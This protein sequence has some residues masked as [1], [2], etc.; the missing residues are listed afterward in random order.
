VD[1]H[2]DNEDK[3]TDIKTAIALSE[4]YN[5]TFS[6]RLQLGSINIPVSNL[7][8]LSNTILNLVKTREQII[9]NNEEIKAIETAHFLNGLN[10]APMPM[11]GP[12]QLSLLSDKQKDIYLVCLK[13]IHRGEKITTRKLAA[14]C[15]KSANTIAVHLRSLLK[16]KYLKRDKKTKCI[17]LP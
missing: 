7:L 9:N 15:G 13:F 11:A 12:E 3:M 8:L 14:E 10:I 4:K 6:K 5:R 17:T 2:V 1:N 16:L